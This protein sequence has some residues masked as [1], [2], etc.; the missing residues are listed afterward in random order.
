MGRKD[1]VQNSDTARFVSETLKKYGLPQP[2]VKSEVFRGRGHDL[3]FLDSHGV[4]IRIGPTNVSDLLNLGILQPIHWVDDENTA[5]TIAIYP[6]IELY[7]NIN[8]HNS[9]FGNV[10]KLTRIIKA[11][12]NNHHDN[13]ARN[14]GVVN[15]YDKKGNERLLP[16][17]LDPD[18]HFL[19]KT[20][21]KPVVMRS[22]LY[23]DGHENIHMQKTH[24]EAIQTVYEERKRLF[25]RCSYADL[26]M[27][28]FEYHQPLRRAFGV[29][30]K[31]DISE[32]EKNRAWQ[33]TKNFRDDGYQIWGSTRA[34]PENPKGLIAKATT[35]FAKRK[36]VQLPK[37][38]L[39]QTR[40]L[41]KPWSKTP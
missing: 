24:I 23:S 4:V 2:C 16:I 38:E 35:V 40:R 5:I 6:G 21:K 14:C 12:G 10:G 30:D 9:L 20:K 8:K 33:M 39:L 15:V 34:T 17:A 37:R 22:N 13:D 18:N 11:F 3:L 36:N 41:H 19:A 32:I 7:K 31:D 25:N 27:Q 28:A 1:Y 29:F 26:Y